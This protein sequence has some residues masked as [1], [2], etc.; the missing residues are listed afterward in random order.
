V[1]QL[2][3]SRADAVNNGL[4]RVAVFFDAA[5]AQRAYDFNVAFLAGVPV[6]GS[7]LGF[8]LTRHPNGIAF[9]HRKRSNFFVFS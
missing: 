6:A 1:R 5:P 4:F 9:A 8:A 7:T 3:A 2:F